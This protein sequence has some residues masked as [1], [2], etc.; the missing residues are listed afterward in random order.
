MAE[1]HIGHQLAQELRVRHGCRRTSQLLLHQRPAHGIRPR[2]AI[3][4]WQGH[5]EEVQFSHAI[6]QFPRELVGPVDL[7]GQGSHLV[8]R[9]LAGQVPDHPLRVGQI[10]IHRFPSARRVATQK[11]LP[12]TPAPPP[13]H[14]DPS[15]TPMRPSDDLQDQRALDHR[16][17][18]LVAA[19]CLQ[20]NLA[21][22][23]ILSAHSNFGLDGVSESN[24][25]S[26]SQIVPV[27]DGPRRRHAGSDLAYHGGEESHG[28][29][30]VGDPPAE[31]RRP[32]KL[33]VHVNPVH[34]ARNPGKRVHV[35]LAHRL[36]EASC[37]TDGQ[38]LQVLSPLGLVQSV[39]P[40]SDAVPSPLSVRPA[41]RLAPLASAGP[42]SAL[43]T[44][45]TA[46]TSM[47]RSSA[48][49]S[50]PSVTAG[51]EMLMA[52]TAWPVK[53]RMGAARHRRP[54]ISSS[55]STATPVRR[56]SSK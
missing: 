28:H 50:S 51:A 4:L 36:T 23:E 55:W 19:A 8:F 32:G 11:G 54:A 7:W 21:P 47:G 12:R 30:P 29:G 44:S 37:L 43:D 53:S 49:R 22:F 6:E 24:G 2:P 48:T 26:E 41:Y 42:P 52:A 9:E 18:A 34:V 45:P 13:A 17:V 33:L 35:R 15:G 25:S 40:P 27:G 10:E 14:A 1:D 20:N 46:S 16:L 5:P 31:A 39:P 38:G 56:T 3:L